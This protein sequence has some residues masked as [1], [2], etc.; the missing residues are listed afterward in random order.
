MQTTSGVRSQLSPAGVKLLS[1]IAHTI[2]L[3]VFTTRRPTTQQPRSRD[4]ELVVHLASLCQR[5]VRESVADVVIE[6]CWCAHNVGAALRLSRQ[7]PGSLTPSQL[8]RV[9]CLCAVT[10]NYEQQRAVV[11][12]FV[13]QGGCSL[14]PA[15]FRL[16]VDWLVDASFP[17]CRR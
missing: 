14:S 13:E 3:R 5:R 1:R 10:S 12:S 6:Y 9:A 2:I 8:L 15:L 11:A 16:Q 7:A 17:V 4:V